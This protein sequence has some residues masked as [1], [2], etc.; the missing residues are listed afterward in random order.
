M[1]AAALQAQPVRAVMPV[2]PIPAT[3]S[4]VLKLC[5][6]LQ[7]CQVDAGFPLAVLSDLTV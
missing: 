2:L 1:L 5:H 7:V 3:A 4:H 6:V